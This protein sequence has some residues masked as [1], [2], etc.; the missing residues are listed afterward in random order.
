MQNANFILLGLELDGYFSNLPELH[1]RK[2]IPIRKTL[3]KVHQTKK[4][5]QR[6]MITFLKKKIVS[7][8]TSP[9]TIH[10]AL[11]GRTEGK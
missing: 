3:D 11:K 1:F 7:S 4:A 2:A 10:V 6:K 9:R 5:L 8:T